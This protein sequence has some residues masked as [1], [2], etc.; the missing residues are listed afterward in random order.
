MGPD[1]PG[2][3]PA[4]CHLAR[5]HH[6]R[7]TRQTAQ[8]INVEDPHASNVRILHTDGPGKPPSLRRLRADRTAGRDSARARFTARAAC[9]DHGGR[10]AAYRRGQSEGD[11]R[12]RRRRGE[13]LPRRR[14]RTCCS[15]SAETRLS[16]QLCAPPAVDRQA[17]RCRG[18]HRRADCR[19]PFPEP[20]LYGGQRPGTAAC[21][22]RRRGGPL[23]PADAPDQPVYL[24][25][26]TASRIN[27][28]G[29]VSLTE[30]AGRRRPG[31]LRDPGSAAA[32]YPAPRAG[33]SCR[34]GRS[35]IRWRNRRPCRCP[36]SFRRG[37][38]SRSR[39]RRSRS[40]GPRCCRARTPGP[41]RC[42]A[43]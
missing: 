32:R 38:P 25:G 27:G 15:R 41:A 7:A 23:R 3:R 9:P 5:I 34:P 19:H 31:S 40:R 17:S 18:D 30:Q 6:V 16:G 43:G 4:G 11:G 24:A 10:T 35:R 14:P 39:R 28:H 12:G 1:L 33:R 22:R 20:G 2:P 21:T 26:F 36:R 29:H 13:C 42:S 8:F 37:R